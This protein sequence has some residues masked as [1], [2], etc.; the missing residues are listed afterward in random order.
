MHKRMFVAVLAAGGLGIGCAPTAFA[1]FV[2]EAQLPP[3]TAVA[4]STSAAAAPSPAISVQPLADDTP[5][6]TGRKVT[7]IGYRP[8]DDYV[9]RGKGR[10]I[11]LGDMMPAIVPKNFRIELGN[12]DRSQIV[13]WSGGLPWDSV[14][15]NAINPL[16]DVRATIDWSQRVVSLRR[17]S[18]SPALAGTTVHRPATA[19]VSANVTGGHA[20]AAAPYEL[21]GGQSLESQLMAWAKRAGWAVSWN[22]PDDFV[23]PHDS[24]WGTDFQTA[25]TNVFEQLAANGADVHADIWKGKGDNTVVV[26]K[27]G[28]GQ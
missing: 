5:V 26:D 13:S 15:T 3:A 2:N 17:D 8:S 10:D 23:P 1:G 27:P 12:V 21:L 18:A 6:S 28:A 11:A 22:T 20:T 14:L 4:A 7:Q 16:A 24:S 19:E 25:V 9:P